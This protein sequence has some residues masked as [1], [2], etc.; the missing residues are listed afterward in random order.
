MT[1]DVSRISAGP[2]I[3]KLILRLA[4]GGMMLLHGIAKLRGGLDGIKGMVASKGL[5]EI[6][7]YGVYVGEV[8]APLL[9]IVGFL[10]R[11]AA[12]ILAINMVVAIALAHSGEIFQLSAH[13]GWAIELPMLFMLGSLALV[14]L[15]AGRFSVSRGRSR[16]D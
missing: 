5:P 3:G 9:L 12:A 4:I 15:G 1:N 2:D 6:M 13:G 10:T 14:F 16:W 8:L 11:P 7:A